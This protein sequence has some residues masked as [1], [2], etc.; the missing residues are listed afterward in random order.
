MT[1]DALVGPKVEDMVNSHVRAIKEEVSKRLESK[2]GD[3]GIRKPRGRKVED[4]GEEGQKED[5]QDNAHMLWAT[6][7]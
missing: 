2:I 7:S 6:A 1:K 5:D 3:F 4:N